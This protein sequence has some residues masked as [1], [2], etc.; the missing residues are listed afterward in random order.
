LRSGRATTIDEARSTPAGVVDYDQRSPFRPARWDALLTGLITSALVGGVY[1][2]DRRRR[3]GGGP[4]P[5]V[6]DE[7]AVHG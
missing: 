3:A 4:S 7:G 6:I 1:W 5:A 2:I